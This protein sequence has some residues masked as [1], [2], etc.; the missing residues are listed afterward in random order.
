MKVYIKELN[1]VKS[2]STYKNKYLDK[3]SIEQLN[4]LGLYPFRSDGAGDTRYYNTTYIYSIE[5]DG[6]Y[7]KRNVLSD[8]PLEDVKYRIK[9]SLTKKGKEKLDSLANGYSHAEMAN[10]ETLAED[11]RRLIVH[12]DNTDIMA[13]DGIT[14]VR[15]NYIRIEAEELGISMELF[16]N[17]VIQ[18]ANYFAEERAKICA[19]RALKEIEISQLSSIEE[20]ID[21]EYSFVETV[22]EIDEMTNEEVTRD[23]YINKSI[24]W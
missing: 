3:L 8:K 14:I 10:W 6:Y 7:W 1:E 13:S 19:T 2:L 16:A 21:Y 22:T 17:K 4:E 23:I 15:P 9:E 5:D 20:C 12:G 11:A 18:K 24:D